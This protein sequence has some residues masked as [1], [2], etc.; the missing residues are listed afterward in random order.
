MF[1]EE[2]GTGVPYP[3]DLQVYLLQAS[4]QTPSHPSDSIC[5]QDPLLQGPVSLL[6][7][8][9]PFSPNNKELHQIF[10]GGSS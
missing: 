5:S 3:G 4:Q 7:S 8:S 9:T 10:T 2:S 6:L 1:S